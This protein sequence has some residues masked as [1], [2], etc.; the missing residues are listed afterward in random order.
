[1]SEPAR[2]PDPTGAGGGTGNQVSEPIADELK[3][4]R[5]VQLCRA[6]RVLLIAADVVERLVLPLFTG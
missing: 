1:M 4:V 3:D 6:G 5:V 2:A